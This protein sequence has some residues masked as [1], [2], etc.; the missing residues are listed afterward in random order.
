ME[1]SVLGGGVIVAVVAALWLLY[2]VP[3]W[4][5][6]HRANV[7][8]RDALR[9]SRA[10]R[11]LAETSETPEEVSAELNAR[12]ALAQARIAERAARRRVATKRRSQ[13]EIE[14]LAAQQLREQQQLEQL[15]AKQALAAVQAAKKVQDRAVNAKGRAKRL[16]QIAAALSLSFM[17]GAVAAFIFGQVVL[18][19]LLTVATLSTVFFT[20]WVLRRR[21]LLVRTQARRDRSAA[22]DAAT[23][24]STSSKAQPLN[25]FEL[26]VSQWTPRTLPRPL[27]ASLGSLSSAVLDAEQERTE[28]E[29]AARESAYVA[30][31]RPAQLHPATAND[32]DASDDA[33]LEAHV[34]EVLR[35]RA[36]G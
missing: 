19:S 34:R 3:S 7:A 8:E 21:A 14:R 27:S 28:T 22:M 13:K 10:M 23:T 15:Q 4:Y 11:V 33:A 18:G 12:D 2:L 1:G 29:R 25:D 20:V 36:A 31:H 35:N 24:A 32:L 17:L 16:T 26:P 5:Q 30:R 9:L 6:S